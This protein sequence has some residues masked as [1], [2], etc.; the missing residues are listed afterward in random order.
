[1]PLTREQFLELLADSGVG[2][3]LDSQTLGVVVTSVAGTDF[4]GEEVVYVSCSMA[5]IP[6]EGIPEEKIEASL[7]LVLHGLGSCIA[8]IIKRATRDEKKR[9]LLLKSVLGWTVKKLE[10]GS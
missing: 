5:E 8:S 10:E 6:D 1:M 3:K 2:S 4:D 7:L 9:E